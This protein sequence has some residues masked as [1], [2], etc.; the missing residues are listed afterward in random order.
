MTG[1]VS[2]RRKRDESSNVSIASIRHAY[3]NSGGT[4]LGLAIV[5]HIVD[6]HHGEIEIESAEQQGTTFTIRLPKHG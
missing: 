5:K 2:I 6:L 1:L 3:R 4:G